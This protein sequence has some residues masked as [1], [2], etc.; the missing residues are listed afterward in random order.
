[1]NLQFLGTTSYKLQ[2]EGSKIMHLMNNGGI[3]DVFRMKR[4]DTGPKIR[5][6]L[7]NNFGQKINLHNAS[8]KFVMKSMDQIGGPENETVITSDSEDIQI[9]DQLSSDTEGQFERLFTEEETSVAGRYRAEFQIK[10]RGS[11]KN[12]KTAPFELEDGQTLLVKVDGE[13]AQ[14]IT[15]NSVDFV[16]ISAASQQEI[17]DA[18]N[19]Q[20]TGAT[21]YAFDCGYIMIQSN[22]ASAGSIQVSGGTAQDTLGFPVDIMS[23]E[24]ISV[25]TE[26]F[27]V[28]IIEDLDQTENEPVSDED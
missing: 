26:K 16:A 22:D 9:L 6:W 10:L 13:A 15:F 14:T 28:Y 8:I 20:I 19:A 7:K 11:A 24:R 5:A 4:H 23:A 21:A 17:V 12:R 27:Y 1:M 3:A 2:V 18:I 25:P